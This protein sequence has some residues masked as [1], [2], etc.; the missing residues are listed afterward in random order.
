MSLAFFDFFFFAFFKKYPNSVRFV[1]PAT[2]R[3]RRKKK[4]MV[5][6]DRQTLSV[7]EWCIGHKKKVKT[8]VAK[9]KTCKWKCLLKLIYSYFVALIIN[10]AVDFSYLNSPITTFSLFFFTKCH[11][12]IFLF[13]IHCFFLSFSHLFNPVLGNYFLRVLLFE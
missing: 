1:Q 8:T 12:P 2:G 5:Q 7:M 6:Y 11:H 13:H 3:G 4:R 9:Q 10:R